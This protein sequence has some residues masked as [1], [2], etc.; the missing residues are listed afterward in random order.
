MRLINSDPVVNL[1]HNILPH[2]NTYLIKLMQNENALLYI[3]EK[4]LRR[5]RIK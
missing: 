5:K 4:K 2:R 3:N 1:L